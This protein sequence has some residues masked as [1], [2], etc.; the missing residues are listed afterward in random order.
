M[1]HQE[2]AASAI[3]HAIRV[4]AQTTDAFVWPAR[5]KAGGG[6]RSLSPMGLWVRPK[7]TVDIS[8]FS[9]NLQVILRALRTHGMTLADNGSPWFL[10]SAPDKC[11]NNDELHFLGQINGSD[12]EAVDPSPLMVNPNSRQRR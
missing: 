1:R 5:R 6:D 7:S 10:G 12:F 11:W 3:D 4:T 8:Q 2:V 9:R